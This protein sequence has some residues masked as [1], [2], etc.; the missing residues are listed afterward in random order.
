MSRRLVFRIAAALIAG[1][2][3]PAYAQSAGHATGQFQRQ[4]RTIPLPVA[5]AADFTAALF[6]DYNA[7]YANYLAFKNKLES[8]NNVTYSLQSSYF[9]QAAT[10][11]GGKPVSLFVY[12]PS[13][14][15][16]PFTDTDWGGGEFNVSFVGNQY[17]SRVTTANQQ[18]RIGAL[19]PPNDWT[20][21]QYTWE[22]VSYTATLPGVLKWLAVTAGQFAIGGF[23]GDLY[24]GNAQT[25]FMT[26]ALAQNATQAYPNAGL[27]SYV[28]ASIANTAVSIN[29][30]FQGAT[31]IT[32]RDISVRGY[33][34]GKYAA[35]GDAMWSPDISGMGAGSYNLV[36]YYQPSVPN[37]PGNS[38]GA[39]LAISQALSPRYGIFA[40]TNYASGNAVQINSSFGGGGVINDPLRRHPND[41]FGIG[42]FLDRANSNVV[43]AQSETSRRSEYGAE[44][45]YNFTLIKGLLI[46]PDAAV[47][48]HPVFGHNHDNALVIAIRLT[49]FL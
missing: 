29:G 46:T 25:N 30:G 47:V 26:Y 20:S 4:T 40:R 27:G 45:Y 24:A 13:A 31:D 36:V 42:V 11:N 48:I 19:T 16:T 9:L 41:Q 10:P 49:Y 21:N 12:A 14:S 44:T 33:Q 39:S 3:S 15:W 6:S 8:S 34:T 28:T 43:G 5:D 22:Q 1:A 35:F 37:Q 23:D 32:G 18:Q 17:W 2:S 38:A 7:L